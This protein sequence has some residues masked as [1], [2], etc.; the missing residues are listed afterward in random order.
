VKRAVVFN[1][2]VGRILRVD[3]SG[4]A[5]HPERNWVTSATAAA[6]M[7]SGSMFQLQSITTFDARKRGKSVRKHTRVRGSQSNQRYF[8]ADSD[9]DAWVCVNSC[10]EEA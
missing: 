5:Y 8:A 10:E 2:E 1:K 4:L 6:V 3:F 7:L 9:L